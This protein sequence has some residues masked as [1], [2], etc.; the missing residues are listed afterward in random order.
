MLFFPDAIAKRDFNPCNPAALIPSLILV[1]WDHFEID[2][3]N[4][5]EQFHNRLFTNAHYSG[6][7]KWT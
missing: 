5:A 1:D 3:Q 4:I 6:G 7:R 2:L